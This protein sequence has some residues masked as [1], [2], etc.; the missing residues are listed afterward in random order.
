MTEEDITLTPE[1]VPAA[2][3]IAAD[4]GSSTDGVPATPTGLPWPK[5]WNGAYLLVISSF[6]LWV[7]SLI[8]LGAVFK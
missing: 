1:S 6:V 7:V 3:Q 8:V 2:T 5:T 4:A